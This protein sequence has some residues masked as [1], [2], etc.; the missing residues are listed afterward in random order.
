[1]AKNF[2]YVNHSYIGPYK[3]YCFNMRDKDSLSSSDYTFKYEEG[4]FLP[5]VSNNYVYGQNLLIVDFINYMVHIIELS[6]YKKSV[7]IKGEVDLNLYDNFKSKAYMS[8]DIY[9]NLLNI[10]NIYDLYDVMNSYPNV[11]LYLTENKFS[12]KKIESGYKQGKYEDVYLFIDDINNYSYNNL[13]LSGYTYSENLMKQQNI[14][15]LKNKSSLELSVDIYNSIREPLINVFED[16]FFD[17]SST[18][19][20][21]N[22]L[23]ELFA[24]NYFLENNPNKNLITYTSFGK[25]KVT[26]IDRVRRDI[27][28]FILSMDE[29]EVSVVLE[30]ILSCIYDDC[31]M[32]S[33][34][35]ILSSILIINN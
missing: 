27:V 10:E 11:N 19:F 32:D 8:I 18:Y 26:H 21:I 20:K 31:Y 6:R 4:D 14:G 3:V 22:Y 5:L 24:I 2:T 9:G 12:N 15:C 35:T 25:K 28:D 33:I 17:K 30:V 13:V 16:S 7:K 34:I 23:L 29:D 1:M